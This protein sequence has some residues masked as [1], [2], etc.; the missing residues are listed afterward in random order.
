[1]KKFKET[2]GLLINEYTSLKAPDKE[3]QLTQ[4]IIKLK[5]ERSNKLEWIKHYN[6]NWEEDNGKKIELEEKVKKLNFEIKAL[7]TDIQLIRD[8]KRLDNPTTDED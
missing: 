2:Y 7:E 3:K 5:K 4:E 1:M 6:K 8:L